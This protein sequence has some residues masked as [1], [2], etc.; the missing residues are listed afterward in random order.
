MPVPVPTGEDENNLNMGSCIR[1]LRREGVTDSDERL[2][3]CFSLWREAHN[4]PEPK[5]KED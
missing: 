3:R 5:P 2:A 4:K 1:A